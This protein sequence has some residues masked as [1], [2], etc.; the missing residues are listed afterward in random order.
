MMYECQLRWRADL[1]SCSAT[2]PP[3]A[4]SRSQMAP[5]TISRIAGS[6]ATALNEVCA[7]T[8]STVLSARSP[9]VTR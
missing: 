1:E 2:K 3:L 8:V 5:K 6:T 9:R 4:R 7:A